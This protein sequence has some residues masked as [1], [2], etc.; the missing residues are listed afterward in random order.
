MAEHE[1]NVNSEIYEKLLA[2]IEGGRGWS[3]NKASREI[4]I[5]SGALS[6]YKN[7]SYNGNVAAVEE[8]I[9]AWLAREERRAASADIPFVMTVM[10]ENF[11]RAVEMAH[12]YKNIALITGEAGAGKTT[13]CRRYA[14]DNPGAAA[15][16]YAYPG[17]SQQKL[18]SEIAGELGL[19]RKGSKSALIDRVVEELRGRDVA[20]IIDQADYLT[21]ASLELLRCVIVD[22]AEAGLVLVG[23]PRLD[24]QLRALRNDHDQLLSRVCGALKVGRM[25]AEDAELIA[26]GVWADVGADALGEFVKSARG[27]VRTL[28]NLI[29]L[30]YRVC[31]I[32]RLD[33]PTAEAVREAACA[34]APR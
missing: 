23:L 4:G 5:S 8:K 9:A 29:K 27:S 17:M 7:K 16:V 12:D 19:G 28:V 15:V 33:A 2:V 11:Y 20:V 1:K 22:M 25:R 32:N 31:A 10:A 26:R 13:A 34:M 14:L 3:L 21:D 24:G 30:A 18:L 6:A